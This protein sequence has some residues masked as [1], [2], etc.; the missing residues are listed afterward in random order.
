MYIVDNGHRKLSHYGS[1]NNDGIDGIGEIDDKNEC[2][3]ALDFLNYILHINIICLEFTET[4]IQTIHR[5]QINQKEL[6]E[7]R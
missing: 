6:L 7:Y 3:V 4:E 5:E 1:I 2:F